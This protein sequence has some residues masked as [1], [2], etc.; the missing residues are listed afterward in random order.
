LLSINESVQFAQD[1]D[2]VQSVLDKRFNNPMWKVTEFFTDEGLKMRIA[3]KNL[4]EFAFEIINNK[5]NKDI[6]GHKD[7]LDIFMDVEI[8]ED[9][10]SN[11]RKLSEKE[12]RDIF[13]NMILAGNISS[14]LNIFLI[15]FKF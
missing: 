5:K 8:T 15:T 7:I 4:S 2:F 13:L 14:Y 3:C 11:K 10:G 1:F 12:L 6:K 9:N